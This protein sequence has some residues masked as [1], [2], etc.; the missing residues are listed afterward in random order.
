MRGTKQE[1]LVGVGELEKLASKYEAT[2]KIL[3]RVAKSLRKVMGE[4]GQ[5]QVPQKATEGSKGRPRA[6]KGHST[7]T[8]QP[9]KRKGMSAEARKKLSQLA[10]IRWAEKRAAAHKPNGQHKTKPVK[11]SVPE[12]NAA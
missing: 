2:A 4:F 1:A 6:R 3:R 5:A 9:P 8:P 12:G 7:A 11:E 10:K